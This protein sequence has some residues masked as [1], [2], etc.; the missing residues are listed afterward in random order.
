MDD[1]TKPPS[2]NKRIQRFSKKAP[3]SSSNTGD[4]DNQFSLPMVQWCFC[5]QRGIASWGTVLS[6]LRID[7]I[8]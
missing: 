4:M 2:Y 6:L 7:R 5:G 8:S 3:I 1:N